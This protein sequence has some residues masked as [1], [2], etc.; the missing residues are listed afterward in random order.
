MTANSQHQLQFVQ[1]S[2]RDYFQIFSI[3][4]EDLGAKHATAAKGQHHWQR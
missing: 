1:L 3:R 4:Q 2:C